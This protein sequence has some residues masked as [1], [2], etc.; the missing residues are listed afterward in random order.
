MNRAQRRAAARRRPEPA[1]RAP[2][3][4]DGMMFV[5][6]RD[7]ERKEW[8]NADGSFRAKVDRL[9]IFRAARLALAGR[10]RREGHRIEDLRTYIRRSP[11]YPR[12]LT[13][14]GQLELHLGARCRG[15]R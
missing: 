8:R 4:L 14:P 3:R 2:H 10:W 15:P 7:L 5:S 1:C 12:T 9:L 11:Q 13:S 6:R